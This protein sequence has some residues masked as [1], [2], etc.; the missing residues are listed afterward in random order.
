MNQLSDNDTLPP[1]MDPAVDGGTIEPPTDFFG[2]VKR[3]GPGLII[4]GSI[5][6]SGE[7]IA[8]TKTGAQA[9][10]SLLWLIIIGCL[11]KVFCQI[12]LGRYAI[13]HGETTLSA[14][15]RV[16]GPK[17]KVNWIMWFWLVMM[18]LIVGQ[19]GGIVGGV[20][21]A[22]ALT[23][24]VKGDYVAAI[25]T[26][27]ENELQR[28]AFYED[29]IAEGKPIL[30]QKTASEQERILRSQSKMGEKIDSLGEEGKVLLAKVRSGEKLED[31]YTIDD[32]IWAA[33]VAVLTSILL[34]RGKYGFIQNFS[35]ALVVTFT[36]ITLVNVF[37]LQASEEYSIPLSDYLRGLSFGLP[38]SGSVK[39][40]LTTALATFG[41]IGVGAA[42]LIAYPYWCLEKGY[43]KFTGPRNDGE[44]WARRAKGWTRVML[45]DALASMAVYTVATL[46]F[47][48]M[49]VAV[50][51]NDGLDPDGMRMV[52]TL[53]AAYVPVFGPY[54]EWLF[55]GGA[56]AVLYST[57]LVANAGNARMVT[58]G[59]K[60]FG[61]IDQHSQKTHDKSITVLSVFLPMLCL[62]VYMSGANPVK[63]VLVAGTMQAIMLPIVGVGALYF[64][65]RKTDPR[66]V[67]SKVWDIV[68][69]A[70]FLGLF[71]AGSWGVYSRFSEKTDPPWKI[72]YSQQTSSVET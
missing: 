18:V 49:G 69:I 23:F 35:T 6:G 7:L 38:D 5:V 15:N 63:L 34:F 26:P 52:G 16:P 40:S 62:A 72:K 47:F 33:L 70:S 68:L 32:K 56:I 28:F 37:S 17:F 8:T 21:Q 54:A 4:A 1:S 50:L 45:W 10:I 71:I 13:T 11:I 53:A 12:E 67:P 46:A 22:L 48:V 29:D 44:D 64:R 30:S 27:S 9:G 31:G 41:I 36:M 65:F 39:D 24:P 20:G 43:A 55:L 58:D 60:I 14:L 51:Y 59:L 2:I 61:V 19:L 25:Q 57:F 3:L 66:L 42:E